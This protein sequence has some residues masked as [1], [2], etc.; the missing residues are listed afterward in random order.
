MSREVIDTNVLTIASAPAAGWVHPRIPLAEL[1]LIDK[2]FRWVKA[3]RDDPT[4]HIVLD[5]GG[6][7]DA[8][9][10]SPQ[11]MPE[12]MMYGRQ[13]IAHKFQTCAVH[14]VELE[15][16]NNGDERV[17]RLPPEIEALIHDLG[18]RKMIAAACTAGAT[19]VNACDSDWTAPG[20]SEAL[21]LLGIELTQ[22]LT[23]DER[24]HCRGT[25]G[26]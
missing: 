5:L 14:M 7:I 8:E 2:V 26:R 20:E 4:R 21:A 13:V 22:I 6:T 25:T 3:F 9:Y 18:D 24:T 11:N 19:L 15:Y 10:K 23:D 12:F 1:R 16:W 17:A